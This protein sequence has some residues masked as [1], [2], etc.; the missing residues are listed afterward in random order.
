MMGQAIRVLVVDDHDIVREG[1]RAMLESKGGIEVIGE[2]GDGEQAVIQARRL[3]PDVILMDLEMPR[4]NGISAIYD[5]IA[6]QPDAR[7]LV[8][9]SFSDDSQIVESMRAGAL[10]YLL[11]TA[12]L[13]DLTTAIRQIYNGETPLNPLVARRL[14]ASISSPRAEPRLIEVLTDRELM[15]L[16]MVVRGMTNKEIGDRLGIALRTVGTHIGNM[17]HKAEVENRVQLSMLAVRQG[18]TS[19]YKDNK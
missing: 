16:P 13:D 1:L 18:L 19:L 10:G 9:S 17:I 15:I 11:K 6:E 5:I 4:K 14:V 3:Q 8:L 2:A 12:K 7:I